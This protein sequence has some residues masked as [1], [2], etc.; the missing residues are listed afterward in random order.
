MRESHNQPKREPN[1]S[2]ERCRCGAD[3]KKPPMGSTK[4]YIPL[5]SLIEA[6][7]MRRYHGKLLTHKSLNIVVG[8]TVA[9]ECSLV[10]SLLC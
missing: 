2:S 8:G 9:V 3:M 7:Q 4:A 6:P 5:V 1:F 10:E